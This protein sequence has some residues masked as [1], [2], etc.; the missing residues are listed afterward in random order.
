MNVKTIVKWGILLGVAEV[1]GT[2]MLTWLGLGLTNWFIIMMHVLTIVFVILS[3]K[4]L[5]KQTESKINFL[6][7]VIL[8]FCIVLIAR[9]IFQIYMFIYIN[10]IDPM[11]LETVA[12]SW[13]TTLQEQ[14]YTQDQIE[15]TIESFRN[16]YKTIPMFTSALLMYAI[17]FIAEGII[18]AAVYLFITKK[19]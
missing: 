19:I 18:I 4:D 2:Q 9:L 14:N 7:A 3:L 17:P 5:K 6:H 8:V 10:Y 1:I 15:N 13:T 16:S 11:W 12:I